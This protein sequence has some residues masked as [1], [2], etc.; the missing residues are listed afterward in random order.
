[1]P[2]KF[3]AHTPCFRSEAGSYGKD[4]RGMIR[5][6]QFEKVELVQIVRPGFLRRARG[7][8]VARRGGAAKAR[9]AV[10]RGAA[11]RRRYRL[12]GARKPTT[13]KSGCRPEHLPGNFLV[14]ATAR[15]SRRGACRLAGATRQR[16]KPEPLHTL[17]GS[18]V[19]VGRALVA[20]MENYQNADGSVGRPEVLRGYMGGLEAIRGSA[21]AAVTAARCQETA[22]ASLRTGR[23]GTAVVCSERQPP[24]SVVGRR[25]YQADRS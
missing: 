19:A 21:I 9:P 17:N 12:C 2:L 7:A 11:V 18:G 15:R 24:A 1:M 13:S 6:H 8:D 3:V 10:P 22:R 25:A 16:G 4:T 23:S 5:Q 14:L 20:V